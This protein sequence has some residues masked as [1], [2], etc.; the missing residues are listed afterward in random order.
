MANDRTYPEAIAS[1]IINDQDRTDLASY[2]Y[3]SWMLQ[4]IDYSYQVILNLFNDKKEVYA[5]LSVGANP[6]CKQIMKTYTPRQIF[7]ISAA[8]N[9]G[10]YFSTGKYVIF[11]NS[12]VI[13]PGD[14]LR[15]VIDEVSRRQISYA[16]GTGVKLRKEQTRVLLP[17][18]QYNKDKNFDFLKGSEHLSGRIISGSGV[19]ISLRKTAL[20]I[21]GM[22]PNILCH[23]DS[24]YS[25]RIMHYLRRTDGQDCLYCLSDMY[26]YHLFHKA[27]ELYGL[28][29]YSKQI[30]EPRRLR[31]IADPQSTEDISSA[32]FS[33]LKSLISDLDLAKNVLSIMPEL[34]ERTL[35]TK[36]YSRLWRAM[37]MLLLGY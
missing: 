21:G 17:P 4:D 25:D 9:L 14:Y 22:D 23:E 13:F 33:S 20:E 27:S 34:K 28:S 10:L 3:R 37:K 7:S 11:A 16:I 19:W 18:E 32:D 6:V 26:G 15:R 29:K 35:I 36:V 30:L 8:N 24:E 2:G 31:L 12:D 5:R 1:I